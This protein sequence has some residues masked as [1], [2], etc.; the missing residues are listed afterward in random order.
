[1]I[2]SVPVISHSI[3]CLR[4][5][6]KMSLMDVITWPLFDALEKQN[7]EEACVYLEKIY[8]Q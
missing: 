2:T 5:R 6:E 4:G 3:S 7:I 8:W 1:M